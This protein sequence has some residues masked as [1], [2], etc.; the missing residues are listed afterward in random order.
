MSKELIH[1]PRKMQN[2]NH[3]TRKI[4]LADE[5]TPGV[6]YRAIRDS[7]KRVGHRF[8]RDRLALALWTPH[9]S[10]VYCREHSF[11]QHK[12]R[13]NVLDRYDYLIDADAAWSV[14]MPKTAAAIRGARRR[15]VPLCNALRAQGF[16]ELDSPRKESDNKFWKLTERGVSLLAQKAL[17]RI[18]KIA[19]QKYVI[20]AINAAIAY[21][22]RTGAYHRIDKIYLFG[23]MLNDVETGWGCGFDR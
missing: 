3:V 19:A 11:R 23:S 12:L 7:I 22:A 5:I 8:H 1:R 18:P 14:R 13:L 9:I 6:T 21:N 16:I 4:D 2:E 17:K 10:D 20:R 15:I